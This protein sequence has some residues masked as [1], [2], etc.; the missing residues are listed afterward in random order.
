MT[1]N[2]LNNTMGAD[3]FEIGRTESDKGPM[4]LIS[5]TGNVT[6]R[7]TH[8]MM[9]QLPNLNQLTRKNSILTEQ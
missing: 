9:S 7:S 8:I 3:Q 4:D 6:E 1:F 2:N 5:K